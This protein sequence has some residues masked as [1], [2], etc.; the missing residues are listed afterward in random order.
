MT[1][2]RLNRPPT[3][4]LL[5]FLLLFQGISATPTGFMLARDPSGGLMQMPLDMLK[6]TP[7]RDYRLPGLILCIVLGL[8]AFFVMGCLF[9]RPDWAWAQRINPF[10]DQHWTWTASAAFGLMLMIWITVQV[11][12]I[13]LGTWLQPLYLGVGLAILLLTLSPAVRAYLRLRTSSAG[14]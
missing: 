2:K 9:I 8:G 11:L 14:R 1:D 6:S 12:M 3:L 10:K 13:T 5:M 7:F 4:W